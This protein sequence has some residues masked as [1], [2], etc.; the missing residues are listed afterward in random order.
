VSAIAGL[1][2]RFPVSVATLVEEVARVPGVEAV[3]LG[4]SRARGMAGPDSDWNIGLYVIAAAHARL[5]GRDTWAL[6]EKGLISR[7]GLDEAA[8]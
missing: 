8:E 2:R 5:A 6:N 7:A 4:G 3:T 1:G